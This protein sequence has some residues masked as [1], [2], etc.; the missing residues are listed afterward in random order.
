MRSQG[1]TCRD[2]GIPYTASWCPI[3][4]TLRIGPQSCGAE[5]RSA[6]DTGHTDTPLGWCPRLSGLSIR[7][8]PPDTPDNVRLMSGLSGPNPGDSSAGF[9]AKRRPR[10][11]F[12]LDD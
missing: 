7:L 10:P 11:V 1:V 3:W 12:G 4:D 2:A 8:A 9:L 5:P 6:P